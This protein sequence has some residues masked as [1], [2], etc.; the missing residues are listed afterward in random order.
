[1]QLVVFG[2][3]ECKGFC[4]PQRGVGG[5]FGELIPLMFTVFLR[6]L[7]LKGYSI[8]LH[9]CNILV[10]HNNCAQRSLINN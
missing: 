9:L 3:L 10:V 6:Q 1:M 8:Y 5:G 4:M 7:L 2:V